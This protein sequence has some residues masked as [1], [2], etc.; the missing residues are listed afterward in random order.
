M[1][2]DFSVLC[3]MLFSTLT[4]FFVTYAKYNF[5]PVFHSEGKRVNESVLCREMLGEERIFS[6][7]L[8]KMDKNSW[9]KV[10]V[11]I[12]TGSIF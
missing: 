12:E 3:K 9:S 2:C 8:C 5:L 11:E 1:K 4:D 7:E 10:E 6:L